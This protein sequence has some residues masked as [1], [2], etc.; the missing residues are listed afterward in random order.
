MAIESV[1]PATGELLRRYEAMARDDVGAAVGARHA[2]PAAVPACVAAQR[3]WA[4]A[5]FEERARPLR[6]AAHLLREDSDSLARLMAL[7]MGKP[8]AQGLAEVEKCAWVCEYY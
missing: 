7:E 3:G 4:G 6:A 2:V 8:L 1:N 5:R